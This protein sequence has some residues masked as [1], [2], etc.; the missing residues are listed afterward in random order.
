M[1]VFTSKIA[2]PSK[3]EAIS[4]TC[5]ELIRK[6]YEEKWLTENLMPKS[7]PQIMDHYNIIR[8][9]EGTTRY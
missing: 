4:D 1:Q 7:V 6:F 5:E 8:I 3:K 9:K 2:H